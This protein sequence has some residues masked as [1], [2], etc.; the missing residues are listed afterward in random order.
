VPT[1][2]R[3]SAPTPNVQAAADTS[4]DNSKNARSRRGWGL[5]LLIGTS[6]TA[7]VLWSLNRSGPIGEQ[8]VTMI[9]GP[10]M[11]TSYRVTLGS[12]LPT[13]TSAAE[14]KSEIERRLEAVNDWMSTYQADSEIS[15][16]NSSVGTEWFDVSTET[17]L[18]IAEALRICELSG[19]AFDATVG[20]LVNL[21]SFGPD[22]RPQRLPTDEEIET[23]MQQVGRSLIEVR[24]SPPALKKARADVSIDLSGIAKG[25]G[26]DQ[27]AD[28]LNRAGVAAYLVDIGGEMRAAGRK[29]DGSA[30]R[31]G[32]EK[33]ADTPN[34]P[35]QI[36]RTIELRDQALA[37]SGDYRNHFEV[38]GV[39]YSHTIDPRTGRPIEFGLASVSVVHRSCMTADALATALMVLGADEGYNFAV[40]Q[41]LA[42]LFVVRKGTAFERRK[43]PEFEALTNQP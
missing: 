37:T 41:D 32:I 7:A 15:K 27:L 30:W 5:L 38:D 6:A 4:A 19:G 28:Y 40:E 29:S 14:L 36:L 20:P 16:F 12:P 21:W 43:T 26:V 10:T 8:P 23:A 18:V 9:T 31:V 2:P 33:P 22:D 17:A 42:V 1:L 11:G 34:A 35:G 3:H 39:R 24:A 25:F 13:D